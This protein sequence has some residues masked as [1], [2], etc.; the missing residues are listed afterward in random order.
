KPAEPS[1]LQSEPPLP[2]FAP[3]AAESVQVLLIEPDVATAELLTSYLREA[4]YTVE[5][6]RDDFEGWETLQR[7]SPRVVLM[8]VLQ[9]DAN[10]WSFLNQLKANPSTKGLPVIMILRPDQQRK[11][12]D[13]DAADYLAKPID[14]AALVAKLSA[15]GLHPQ[16]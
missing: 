10:G 3:A 11:D 4:G 12:M 1:P 7:L 15:L 8:D 6:A 9:P 13:L 2:A 16:Q 5:S 14:P